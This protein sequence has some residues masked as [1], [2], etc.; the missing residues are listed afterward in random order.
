M[1]RIKASRK[2]STKKL[3]QLPFQLNSVE[4]EALRLSAAYLLVLLG[5]ILGWTGFPVVASGFF[6]GS[7]GVASMIDP[8]RFRELHGYIP[9][10]TE[11]GLLVS[12]AALTGFDSVLI[13]YFLVSVVA[14]RAVRKHS[15]RKSYGRLARNILLGLG[16]AMVQM[17]EFLVLYFV[18][19]AAVLAVRDVA[20]AARIS[21]PRI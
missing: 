21:W 4:R 18:A 3:K 10:V 19:A 8:E 2:F 17:N 1:R 12:M 11:G 6:L 5:A 7:I 16:L 9:V 15:P 13:F 20:L 14:S